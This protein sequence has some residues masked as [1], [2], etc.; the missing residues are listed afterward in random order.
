MSQFVGRAGELERLVANLK[1]A[2]RSQGSC[3]IV[4]GEPGIGKSALV[5]EVVA[6]AKSLGFAVSSGAASKESMQPF[7]VFS[8]AMSS[9]TSEPLF[10]PEERAGFIS[11]FAIGY[12]DGEVLANASQAGGPDA[13][14]LAGM[15]SAVQGFVKDSFQGEKGSLGRIEHGDIKILLERSG[16]AT[17]AAVVANAESTEMRAALGAAAEKIA[18]SPGRIQSALDELA[19]LRFTVRKGLEGLKLESERLRI[20]HKVLQTLQVGAR[21]SPLL[22]VLEDV[23]WAD[24]SSLYVLR[25]VARNLG[26]SKVLLL[27][28]A[29]PSEGAEAQKTLAAMRAEGAASDIALTGLDPAGVRGLVDSALHPNEFQASFTERLHRDCGGNPFFVGELLRQMLADGAIAHA[30]GKY[31]LAGG[32]Y[33]MPSS[34]GEVVERRLQSL[35]E[36]A[37][38]LAEYVSCIGRTFPLAAA[39]SIHTIGEPSL[40]L[41]RLSESGVVASSQSSGEFSHALFQEAVY[42]KISPRWRTANHRSLGEHYERANPGRERDVAYELAR[43]FSLS[44]DA[45][46]SAA[47]N[48]MAGEKALAVFAAGQAAAYFEAALES[49]RKT[50][51]AALERREPSLL[52]R[53]GDARFVANEYDKALDAYRG[54]LAHASR[55]ESAGVRKM[56]AL[57]RERK[58]DY[59]GSLEECA[60][61]LRLL[62]GAETLTTARLLN[63]EAA[64]LIKLGEYAS[65]E[66]R[67][68]RA[69]GIATAI[70][71]A[72]EI[73]QIKHNLASVLWCKGEFAKELPLLLET[74]PERERMG[75]TVGL[76]QAYN[77]L[78]VLY[79]DM[80]AKEKAMECHSKSLALKERAGNRHGM[81][82]SLS[83]I[84]VLAYHAGD[85]EL[86]REN[87]GRGRAMARSIGDRAG[88]ATSTCNLANVLCELGD[89]DGGLAMF[90]EALDIAR[91]IGKRTLITR[92]YAGTV[93]PLLCI[94]RGAEALANAREGLSVSLALKSKAEEVMSRQAL[95]R[96]LRETGSLDEAEAEFDK[97]IGMAREVSDPL[98]EANGRYDLGI[99]RSFRGDSAGA[100]RELLAARE[101][102]VELR[103]GLWIPRCE[104]MLDALRKGE[105]LGAQK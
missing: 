49:L 9:L 10:E 40:A 73:V 26:G 60:E 30:S 72:H 24:E 105:P 11:V 61:G 33:A 90:N 93:E 64:T 16:E 27:A 17:I 62:A 81:V 76:S 2:G 14:A 102:F 58:G 71:D 8:G 88:T 41:R 103:M 66:E 55:D 47:Y 100:E 22:V 21:E 69:L 78:G 75:D 65:A 53:I 37:M 44:G 98:Q 29:R 94:G 23:H 4:S 48:E 51:A 45:A 80:G 101:L 3:A 96:A 39:L 57:T 54:A 68:G 83:N 97:C 77:N 89:I 31:S 46:K 34:V 6:R 87:F 59:A 1:D 7:L 63:V 84:G 25:Y 32:D 95:G 104:R 50:G 5:S 13:A 92:S 52:I 70:R 19:K 99:L 18:L 20:A 35:D 86:A 36:E 67:L 56:M 79:N 82:T 15:I 74:I 43:H 85:L 91:A 42:A 38:A 12:P 28:T